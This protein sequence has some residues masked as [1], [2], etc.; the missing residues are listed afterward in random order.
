M[1]DKCPTCRAPVVTDSER[2]QFDSSRYHMDAVKKLSEISALRGYVDELQQQHD[3]II[4]ALGSKGI[5][6]SEI[7][8]EIKRLSAE[9]TKYKKWFDDNAANLATHRIGGFS[10]P[11]IQPENDDAS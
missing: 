6:P 1:T 9:V 11:D 10:F 4:V 5:L 8:S 3:E 7:V 2:H